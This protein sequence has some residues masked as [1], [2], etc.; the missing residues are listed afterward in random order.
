MNWLCRIR[1]LSNNFQQKQRVSAEG[2]DPCSMLCCLRPVLF[3]GLFRP[4]SV[5]NVSQGSGN[6]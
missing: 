3:F 6:H 1:A 2:T 5:T 4:M